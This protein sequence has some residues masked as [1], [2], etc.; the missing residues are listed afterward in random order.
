MDMNKQ[1]DDIPDKDSNSD[2]G[3]TTSDLIYYFTTSKVFLIG[4]ICLI[5]SV[6]VFLTWDVLT[7]IPIYVFTSILLSWAWYSPIY[8]WLSHD[9]IFIDVIDERDNIITTWRVG[10]VIY[11]QMGLEGLTNVHYSLTGNMRILATDFNPELLQIKNSWV[12]EHSPFNFFRDKGTLVRFSQLLNEVYDDIIDGKAVAQIEGRKHAMQTMNKHYQDL[13]SVFFGSLTK[14][15]EGGDTNGR[16]T[17]D[18][19]VSTDSH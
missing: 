9:S 15:N 17:T 5:I 3:R 11:S 4:L 1:D 10:K 8:K 16:E 2:I 19:M 13:D 6:A 14:D 7:L 18:D 12:H